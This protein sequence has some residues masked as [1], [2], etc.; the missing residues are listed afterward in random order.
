MP[1]M[2][3]VKAKR[4]LAALLKLGFVV[5]RQRG[6]HAVL[7]HSDGRMTVVP[8]HTGDVPPGTLRAI[9]DDAHLEPKDIQ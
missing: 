3:S 5:I 1:K 2:P 9:L 4:L 8:M 7:H 6:G